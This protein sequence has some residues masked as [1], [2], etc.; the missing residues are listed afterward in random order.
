[1]ATWKKVVVENSTGTISQTA[2]AISSQGALATLATVDTGQIDDS[3]I[4]TAKIADLNVTTGKLAADAVTGAKIAND[5][6]N[7]EHYTNAS[8]DLAH[9]SS[10]SVDEDNLYISNAGTNG[11]FLSKQSGNNGGLT[12]ATVSADND[13]VSNSNLLTKLAALESSSGT[14][15]ETITI[16]T[17]SGDT[18]SFTGKLDVANSLTADKSITLNGVS[19]VSSGSATLKLA[20]DSQQSWKIS[21]SGGSDS[22]LFTDG[23]T[24]STS[25]LQ[26]AHFNGTSGYNSNL[27]APIMKLNATTSSQAEVVFD[28]NDLDNSDTCYHFKNGNVKV[29]GDLEVAGTTTT[30]NTE[31]ILLAD[32]NI[33]LNSNLTGTTPTDGGISIERGDLA[34]VA[35]NW[36]ESANI[37]QVKR[38]NVNSG[39]G[40][41]VITQNVVTSSTGSSAPNVNASFIGQ[42]FIDSDDDSIHIYS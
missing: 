5:A 33:V 20:G 16:G 15:D 28:C 22:L 24:N 27:G 25:W 41:S 13:D 26:L 18:V 35:L 38:K 14:S 23:G 4:T 1:M 19:G 11:Q 42:I 8:I 21:G 34:N 32:N 2:A 17:D 40:A 39:N 7:S 29:Y 30:V 12:W 37:W 6:I 3:A 10:E 36:D 9:M 31:E